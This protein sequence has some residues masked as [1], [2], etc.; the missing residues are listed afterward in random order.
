MLCECG[1]VIQ[2]LE[3][4]MTVDVMTEQQQKGGSN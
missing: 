1:T 2:T 4:L 3:D